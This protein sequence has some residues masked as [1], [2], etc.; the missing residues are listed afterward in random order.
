MNHAVK[1]NKIKSLE[2]DFPGCCKNI[3]LRL[4]IDNVIK[5]NKGYTKKDKDNKNAIK[6]RCTAGKMDGHDEP[7]C[8]FEHPEKRPTDWKD[9]RKDNDDGYATSE[10]NSYAK[11][12]LTMP[13]TM[14]ISTPQR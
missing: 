4:S 5:N 7:N 2:D 9:R 14:P 12:F 11:S 6:K 3:L 10:Y 13:I 1:N 8:W